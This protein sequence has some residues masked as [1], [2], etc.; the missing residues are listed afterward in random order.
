MHRTRD[1]HPVGCLGAGG[2]R[3]DSEAVT[4]SAKIVGLIFMEKY[5]I[6]STIMHRFEKC[7]KTNKF[8]DISTLCFIFLI[9][10][11]TESYYRDS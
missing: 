11:F 8:A 6:V 1:V 7:T 3:W 4:G 10:R 5:G 2:V 9:Q